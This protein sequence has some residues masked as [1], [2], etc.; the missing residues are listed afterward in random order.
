MAFCF[1]YLANKC[2]VYKSKACCRFTQY[3]ASKPDK[4]G[5]KFCLAVDVQ[6][7]FLINGFPYLG[8]DETRPANQSLGASVVLCLLEPCKGKERNVTT[9]NF[10]TSLS[11]A[12]E[13]KKNNTSLVRTMNRVRRE[14]PQSATDT[15]PELY[16]TKII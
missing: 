13:L 6:S 12:K 1:F 3:F 7:K 4:Y 15:T 2:S 5:I 10:F 11:L 14:L 16:F 9:D 8:K